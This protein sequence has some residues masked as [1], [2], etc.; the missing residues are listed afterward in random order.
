MELPQSFGISGYS[1]YLAD[2]DVRLSTAVSLGYSHLT[3]A[4][5]SFP[6]L[7]GQALDRSQQVHILLLKP[8]QSRKKNLCK[9]L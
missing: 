4:R 7:A 9:A 3:I 8:L 2:N 6:A 1:G 5:N